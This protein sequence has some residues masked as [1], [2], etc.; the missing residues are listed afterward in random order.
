MKKAISIILLLFLSIT[1]NLVLADNNVS[2]NESY[3]D[4]YDKL[5]NSDLDFRQIFWWIDLTRKDNPLTKQQDK[6]IKFEEKALDLWIKNIILDTMFVL[7]KI[8]KEDYKNNCINKKNSFCNKKIKTIWDYYSILRTKKIKEILKNQEL[9]EDEKIKI[10]KFHIINIFIHKLDKLFFLTWWLDLEKLSLFE[11]NKD[12]FV[13][14]LYSLS[15][16]AVL[17]ELIDGVSEK[18]PLL[19]WEK[20]E[21]EKMIKG[22]QEELV[23]KWIGQN[24]KSYAEK[25]LKDFI[26]NTITEYFNREL[27]EKNQ[28]SIDNFLSLLNTNKPLNT[29][30]NIQSF[31]PNSDNDYKFEESIKTKNYQNALVAISETLNDNI[32]WKIWTKILDYSLLGFASKISKTVE[33]SNNI[34]SIVSTFVVKKIILDSYDNINIEIFDK[35]YTIKDNIENK[36]NNEFIL[37]NEHK[38]NNDKDHTLN[39]SESKYNIGYT[40]DGEDWVYI[41]DTFYSW[42]YQVGVWCKNFLYTKHEKN[43]NGDFIYINWK[44]TNFLD[45]NWNSIKIHHDYILIQPVYIKDSKTWKINENKDWKIYLYN[46]DWKIK[47]LKFNENKY[48]RFRLNSVDINKKWEIWYI[49]SSWEVYIWDKKIIKDLWVNNT[50]TKFTFDN[51]NNYIIY[52]PSYPSVW[53]YLNWKKLQNIPSRIYA[54]KDWKVLYSTDTKLFINNFEKLDNFKY[55]A[56][57]QKKLYDLNLWILNNYYDI[58]NNIELSKIKIWEYFENYFWQNITVLNRDMVYHNWK[59]FVIDWKEIK[60]SR[61]LQIIKCEK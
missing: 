43:I 13:D 32:L 55:D 1:N 50:S 30:L 45:V 42:A 7:K 14:A 8:I 12:R 44:K 24:I 6:L 11:Q 28:N 34:E 25:D 52:N 17:S 4:F 5:I 18:F 40:I 2:A 37:V 56:T 47:L 3:L 51:D 9:N 31:R 35:S 15:M 38:I 10:V 46:K 58:W 60:N 23:K 19:V 27:I 20:I 22:I 53:I 54:F 49:N 41:N 29:K 48:I 36:N 39:K 33:I 26:A 21:I 16:W 57:I 61:N 59:N